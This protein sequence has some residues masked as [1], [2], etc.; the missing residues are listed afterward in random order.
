ME[1]QTTLTLEA[2]L[3]RLEDIEAI[4][5]LKFRYARLCDNAYE[6]DGLAALFMPDAV[7]ES[8]A[9]GRY[10]GRA[11]IR[12]F[13]AGV[14]SSMVW[15]VHYLLSPVIDVAADGTTAHGSW[16]ILTLATMSRAGSPGQDSVIVSGISDERFTRVDGEWLIEYMNVD[17]F[18]MSNLDEGWAK[19]PFRTT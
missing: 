15:S 19:R 3:D 7:W 16:Y 13:F 10:R 18:Q 14:S 4:K 9:F 1:S 11:E 8:P 5:A 12:E 2:R 6:P 17:I